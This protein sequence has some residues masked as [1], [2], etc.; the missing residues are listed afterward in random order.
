[1][2]FFEEIWFEISK[3]LTFQKNPG[4]KGNFKYKETVC[5]IIIAV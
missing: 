2:F 4:F 1:M 5:F 3:H